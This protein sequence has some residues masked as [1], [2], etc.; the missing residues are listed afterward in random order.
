MGIGFG[1]Q[2]KGKSRLVYNE[3]L[4]NSI[5]AILLGEPSLVTSSDVECL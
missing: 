2:V 3:N 1:G 4:V 5:H